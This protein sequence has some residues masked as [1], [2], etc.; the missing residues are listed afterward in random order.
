MAQVYI[1]P[2]IQE[3][4]FNYLMYSSAKGLVFKWQI[5]ESWCKVNLRRLQKTLDTKSRETYQR[6]L[7]RMFLDIDQMPGLSDG[8]RTMFHKKMYELHVEYL[9]T[10]QTAKMWRVTWTFY[11]DL[12]I[13]PFLRRNLQEHFMIGYI[14]EGSF[15]TYHGYL[16]LNREMNIIETKILLEAH[17]LFFLQVVGI[18]K[19]SIRLEPASELNL[20]WNDID[21]IRREDGE[22]V[23]FGNWTLFEAQADNQVTLQYPTAFSRYLLSY[24]S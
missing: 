10:L 24:R 3:K 23:S 12:G 9:F 13:E 1:P 22:V 20:T 18:T 11:R 4:V 21:N 15:S 17:R 16:L 6:E 14:S 5:Q 7:V 19:S 2:E 8:M